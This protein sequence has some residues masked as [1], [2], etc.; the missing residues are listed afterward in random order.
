M[1]RTSILANYRSQS[2]AWPNLSLP[3]SDQ[4]LSQ[5]NIKGYLDCV[6]R[7]IKRV[8]LVG[9]FRVESTQGS[10]A[11]SRRCL[12]SSEVWPWTV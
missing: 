7:Q 6:Y 1:T 4:V 12:L 2:L 10:R 3:A 9:Y 11:T 5:K 8:L